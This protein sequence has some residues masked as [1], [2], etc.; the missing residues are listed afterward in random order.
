[1]IEPIFVEPTSFEGLYTFCYSNNEIDQDLDSENNYINEFDRLFEN[2]TDTEY[3]TNYLLANKSYIE[4]EYFQHVYIDDLI[5]KIINEAEE[6][7]QLF[8]DY[9]ETG[10]LDKKNSL[11]VIFKPLKNKETNLPQ[12]QF[13]KSKID[14]RKLFP[15]PILRVYA[16]R[17]SENTFIVTGGCIKLTRLMNEHPD[18]DLEL[19]KIENVKAYLK[20]NNLNSLDDLIYRYE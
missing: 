19:K 15:R 14:N 7:E 11:Q 18:T 1:M 17:M 9:A 13:S 6:L 10:F 12:H 5:E 4:T 20:K 3:V 16:I 8:Y 2:W